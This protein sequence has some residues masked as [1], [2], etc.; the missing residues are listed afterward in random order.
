VLINYGILEH[1]VGNFPAG[2][3]VTERA[4]EI[5]SSLDDARG[6]ATAL[7]NLA[8]LHAAMG[9]GERAC[10]EVNESI[11]MSRAGGLRLNE[12][13]ALENLAIATASLGNRTEAIRL[14]HEAL[15]LHRELDFSKWSGRLMG[16][17]A[18]WHAEVG[19]IDAARAQVDEMLAHDVNLCSEWRQRFYWAA[20][21]VLHACGEDARARSQ[22][23]RAYELFSE[24]AAELTGDDLVRYESVPWNQAIIAAHNRGQWP[25]FPARP[26]Q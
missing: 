1:E 25:S 4:L 6:K 18:V 23:A 19:D 5:F 11:E 8:T 16:D 26:P 22:L 17:L 7:A 9:E 10:R 15:A 12:A 21:Q 13:Q 24:I 3:T 2:V 14:A 20:A